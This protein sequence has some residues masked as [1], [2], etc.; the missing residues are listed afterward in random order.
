MPNRERGGGVEKAREDA[1]D[2]TGI[3]T[4]DNDP[5]PLALAL[6]HPQQIRVASPKR[7]AS[8]P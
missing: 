8:L 4:L 1:Y 6:A 7:Y 5:S 3:S 2:N